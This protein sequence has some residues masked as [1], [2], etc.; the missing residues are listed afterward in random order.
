MAQFYSTNDHSLR[1]T[2]KQA[3]LDGMPK[4]KGLFTAIPNEIPQLSLER[5]A[6]MGGMS[7]AEIAF[8][9]LNPWIGDELPELRELMQRAYP[10]TIA[11]EM[12]PYDSSRNVLMWLTKGPT[13]SFKDYAGQFYGVVLDHILEQQGLK[14]MVVVAT[15]GDTGGALAS[16][17]HKLKNVI[18]VVFYPDGEISERQRRQMTT[19]QENVYA[20]AVNGNFDVCQAI[21]KRLLKDE[22]LAQELFN[23]A[24]YATSAN[25]ISLGR[26]LPQI[27][28]PF[29]AHSRVAGSDEEI[30][31]S[32]PS[33]NQGNMMGAVLAGAMGLPIRRMLLGFNMSSPVVEYL[34]TGDYIV[35]NSCD[36][37]STAMN[38]GDPSGMKRLV[39]LF[40]GHMYDKKGDLGESIGTIDQQPDLESMREAFFAVEVSNDYHFRIMRSAYHNFGILLDP[41]GAAGVGAMLMYRATYPDDDTTIV[42]D[43]TADPGKFPVAVESATGQI[44]EVPEGM[45]LQESLSERIYRISTPPADSGGRKVLSEAQYDEVRS[46]LREIF[47]G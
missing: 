14:R 41:H 40:G 5:I 13:Y 44:P 36:V 29:Y 34:Q 22:E 9:V 30:I 1:V 7:Y 43:E 26:Q 32:K 28:Y 17:L 35:R 37:P 27:V 6:S 18:N 19:L 3:L 45:R 46:R 11:P 8:E 42:I 33:G 38:V 21:A 4:D 25:S 24:N 47:K 2:F 39:D 23:D 16:S 12:Q 31:L 10:A 20:F 15:S